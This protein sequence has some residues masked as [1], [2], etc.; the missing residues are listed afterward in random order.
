MRKS[1]VRGFFAWTDDEVE[2]LLK[3][4]HEYKAVK[5]AENMDWE[6]CQS[7]Y[8]DIFEWYGERYPSPEEAMAMGKE[9]PHKKYELTKGQLTSKVKA[10]RMRYRQAV[11]L[12]RKRSRGRVVLLYFDLCE[13]IWGGSPATHAISE[14]IETSD[15]V[16]E[17]IASTPNTGLS[18]VLGGDRFA[19]DAMS[20]EIVA[21]RRQRLDATLS[22]YRK[23][24]L[25]RKQSTDS[26]A[27]EDL[28]IKRQLLQQFEETNHEFVQIMC[29]WS[30]TMDRLTSNVELLVQHFVGTSGCVN[31][32]GCSCKH[33][34]VSKDL[35]EKYKR[36]VNP[37][38]ALEDSKPPRIKEE[39]L[40][41]ISLPVSEE[42]GVDLAS[43]DQA[44]PVGALGAHREKPPAGLEAA[45]SLHA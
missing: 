2:L 9:Y 4:T 28:D 24:K 43:G 14:G 42:P 25:K 41:D 32:C 18:S 10:I 31:N 20:A 8:S 19:K 39:P 13:S 11:N 3:V 15:V 22:G 5:A 34:M 17:S 38:E 37:E 12:G 45:N 35:S 30:S 33:N 26:V 6:S 7:K 29:Q 23:E 27:Q 1:K 36:L 16:V 40:R 44:L 21:N